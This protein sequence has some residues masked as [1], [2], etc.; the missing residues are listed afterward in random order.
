MSDH[1]ELLGISP[2]STEAQ[3]KEAWRQKAGI[4]HP[5]RPTGDAAKFHRYR[6]AYHKALRDVTEPQHCNSCKGTGVYL[7]TTGFASIK[8]PCVDCEGMGKR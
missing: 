8:L 6:L 7:K 4:W 5:D 2:R 3:V 1:F